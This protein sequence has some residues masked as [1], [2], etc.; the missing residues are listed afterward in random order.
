MYNMVLGFILYEGV[1]LI[2]NL[3]KITYN[4]GRGTYYW[5]YNTDYPEVEREKRQIED[6]ETLIQR[7]NELEK[8]LETKTLLL[9]DS[10]DE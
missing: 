1:D 3:G 6:M 8:K 10:K 9:E 5:W 7:I 4:A 2:V